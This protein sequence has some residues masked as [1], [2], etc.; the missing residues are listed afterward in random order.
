MTQLTTEQPAPTIDILPC[1]FCGG[2]GVITFYDKG[3]ECI[4]NCANN[5]CCSFKGA[6][7]VKALK[8]WSANAAL[9]QRVVKVD[10]E[11][12]R[13]S[14]EVVR[15]I[16]KDGEPVFHELLLDLD[17]AMLSAARREGV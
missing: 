3:P 16:K 14:H 11:L 13:R 9:Q 7:E 4:V 6:D 17:A 5:F 10:V 12:L 2:P 8:R 1:P 15:L